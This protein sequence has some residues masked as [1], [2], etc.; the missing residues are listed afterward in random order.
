M[1][2]V[3]ASTLGIAFLFVISFVFL[4]DS[5]AGVGSYSQITQSTPPLT[6]P[7]KVVTS[8]TPACSPQPTPL[9]VEERKDRIKEL[10]LE[11]YLDFGLGNADLDCDG[12]RNSKDNCIYLYN[13]NQKDTNGDGKGDA[14]DLVKDD[15]SS[16]DS[17]CD[18]DRD[19]IPDFR[20]NC[21]LA[22]NPDQRDTNKNGIGDVCDQAFPHAV[23]TLQVCKK[24]MKIKI[25]RPQ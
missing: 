19:G 4:N 10:S 13:P 5:E 14:C 3:T 25:L 7:I 12:I 23:L 17:R 11:K 21:L 16:M 9:S 8:P 2:I 20:D 24:P 22:C 1:K 18:E 6:K 15:Y